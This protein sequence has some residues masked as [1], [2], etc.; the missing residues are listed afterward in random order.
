[1]NNPSEIVPVATRLIGE[2]YCKC[3]SSKYIHPFVTDVSDVELLKH[4]IMNSNYTADSLAAFA[5]T[6]IPTCIFDVLA[7]AAFGR[8]DAAEV[9]SEYN[10]GS[11]NATSVGYQFTANPFTANILGL[12][13]DSDGPNGRIRVDPANT[14]LNDSMTRERAT[15]LQTLY[16]AQRAARAGGQPVDPALVAAAYPQAQVGPEHTRDFISELQAWVDGKF[17]ASHA[18]HHASMAALV[19]LA[20]VYADECNTAADSAR[21]AADAL[22]AYKNLASA[23]A[24]AS[25][26]AQSAYKNAAEAAAAAAATI[27]AAKA[28]KAAKAAAVPVPVLAA[29]PAA[30]VPVLAATPAVDIRGAVADLTKAVAALAKL[31]ADRAAPATPSAQ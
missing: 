6:V 25:A 27:T 20:A 15:H 13:F 1:M 5:A 23:A 12:V 17:A 11:K 4:L 19:T 26:D 14:E 22:S 24:A 31:L 21:A 3:Y 28:A 30:A 8:I 29:T 2:I 7:L 16:R 18:A 9:A 10:R